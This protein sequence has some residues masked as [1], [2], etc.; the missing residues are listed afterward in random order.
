MGCFGAIGPWPQIV[1]KTEGF[2]CLP[3]PS[4]FVVLL[5]AQQS[6]VLV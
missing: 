2:P 4:E 5:V 6:L 1:S 3:R